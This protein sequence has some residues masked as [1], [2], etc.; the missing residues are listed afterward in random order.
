MI[1]GRAIGPGETESQLKFVTSSVDEVRVGEFVY[2]NIGEK[3]ILCRVT[4]REEL[5][6]Y[7]DAFL[8]NENYHPKEIASTLG[9]EDEEVERYRVKAKILGTYD[10]EEEEFRNLRLPP[11]A[12]QPIVKAEDDYL[13]KVL[14]PTQDYG[15]LEVGSL[16]NREEG[17]VKVELDMNEIMS[18]HLSVLASTGSGK[19]YTVGVLLEELIKENNRASGIVIDIHGEYHTLAEDE[20]IGDHFELLEPTIRISNMEVQDFN[21]ASP[22]SFTPKMRDRL[23]EIIQG[24][25]EDN[26]NYDFD[27]ITDELDPGNKT[28][29]G[30]LWRINSFQDFNIFSSGDETSL[31]DL[32]HSGTFSILQFPE[33][34]EREE[35]VAFAYFVRRILQARENYS[36]IR[37][38]AELEG[39]ETINFPIMIFIEEAHNFAPSN[40]NVPTRRLLQRVA[41]EGRKFGVGLGIITQRPSRI[42]EDVLSQC[43]SNIIMKIRNEADQKSIRRSVESASEDL[44]NDLPGL[45]PGQAVIAGECLHTPVLAQ[46]RERRTKH[47]GETPNIAEISVLAFEEDS[48]KEERIDRDIV[49]RDEELL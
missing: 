35:K 24:L 30:I 29:A 45:T 46:I 18:K 7:P 41:R 17:K 12:G 11:E 27:D 32:C 21:L 19:S 33:A 2:Y 15:L 34:T 4:E 28:G 48:E 8:D 13:E 39:V 38:G 22:E 26:E 5:Q 3:Q 44:I 49:N 10:E 47:G 31:R 16:L 40:E 6:V 9:A 1:V 20:D 23:G 43:N 14:Y 25:R 36:R 42:D 37:R